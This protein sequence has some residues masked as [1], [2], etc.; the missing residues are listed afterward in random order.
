MR[1]STASKCTRKGTAIT[2]SEDILE[3]MSLKARYFRTLDTKQWDDFRSL[4]ADNLQFFVDE[5]SHES[6]RQL[7]QTSAAD[8]PSSVISPAGSYRTPTIVGADEFV[9]YISR[10]LASAITVHQGHTPEIVVSCDGTA[11]GIWAMYDWVEDV[12]RGLSLKGWGHYHEE[13][14]LDIDGRWQ[15]KRMELTRLRVDMTS[16]DRGL[17]TPVA[18]WTRSTAAR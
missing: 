10:S 9:E 13:Y 1:K 4:F 8:S 2:A 16:P 17:S 11:T 3:L 12:H 15:I 18:P 6:V 7:L 14:E 5:Q